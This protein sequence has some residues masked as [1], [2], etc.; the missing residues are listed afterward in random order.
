VV[1][2]VVFSCTFFAGRG[3]FDDG[4]ARF[5]TG[6]VLEAV[7]YLHSRGIVYRDLKPENLILDN[8]G[9][10]KLVR[11]AVFLLSVINARLPRTS[12]NLIFILYR[13]FVDFLQVRLED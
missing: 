13:L 2:V 1:V 8:T 12:V 3:M 11:P 10:A 6:C 5:Y 7:I 9:Y 4:T